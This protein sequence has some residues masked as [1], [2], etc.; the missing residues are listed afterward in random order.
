[1]S[2]RYY[3]SPLQLA[4]A[5]VCVALASAVVGC[6]PKECVFR[7]TLNDPANRSMRQALLRQG[8]GDFCKQMLERNA[9]L[10]L[11]PDSPII[12][13]FYPTHCVAPESEDL[14]VRFD[15][16]GYA[17]T[18]V[19]KKMTFNMSATVHYRYDFLLTEGDRC[20]VYAYFR[21]NRIEA[22]DFRTHVIEA[23]AASLL[24]GLTSMGDTFGNQLV[25]SKLRGGFTVI[26][27]T[28]TNT[29]EFGLGIVPIGQKSFHPYQVHGKDRVTYENERVEVHQN[30]RD[31]VG[32]IVVDS[33]RALFV[34]ASLDGAP[35]ARVMIMRKA[36]AE[37]SLNLYYASPQAGPLAASPLT[38]DILQAG[39]PFMRAISVPP[40]MYY[41]VFDNSLGQVSP[42]AG[43]LDDRAAVINYLIQIGDGS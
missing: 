27:T 2:S 10:R 4:F 6:G 29:N 11:S 40:G 19:T 38:S 9:P 22:S 13:R 17:Y 1:M 37:A 33:G 42:P 32:P 7:G 12:G 24:N 30:E 26:R 8:M 18:N 34:T 43:V 23:P 21:P 15:G 31:F 16:F 5:I 41:V 14:F 36:E 3:P 35:A 20:D 39:V 28:A 25:A